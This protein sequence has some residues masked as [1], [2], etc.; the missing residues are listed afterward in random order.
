MEEDN[1]NQINWFIIYF[2]EIKCSL[3]LEKVKQLMEEEL[4]LLD[5]D[6]TN[7]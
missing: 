7:R 3:L 6:N 5:K 1:G 2:R 4:I